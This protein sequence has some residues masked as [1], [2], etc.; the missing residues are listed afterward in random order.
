MNVL[1]VLA[2]VFSLGPLV[3]A[4]RWD[5]AA[6]GPEGIAER[7]LAVGVLAA[8]VEECIFRHLFGPVRDQPPAAFHETPFAVHVS[9]EQHILRR[10]N[11]VARAD[12]TA[13][14]LWR[15]QPVEPVDFRPGQ[16]VD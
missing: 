13:G 1:R 5:Q 6:P 16:M 14:I 9:D 11:I 3:V 15:G 8:H 12:I 7:R 2:A 4:I 10:G